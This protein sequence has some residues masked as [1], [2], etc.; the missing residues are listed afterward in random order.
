MLYIYVY[1]IIYN[2]IHAWL[3]MDAS[4]ID[5]PINTTSS[6]KPTAQ[7]TVTDLKLFVVL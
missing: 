4:C 5:L 2:S 3:Y 6:V 1:I 7:S